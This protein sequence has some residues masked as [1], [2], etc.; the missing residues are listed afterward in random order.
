M[1]KFWP[2][3][4][5]E[6]YCRRSMNSYSIGKTSL[7]VREVLTFNTICLN[8][9]SILD[10]VSSVARDAALS[11]PWVY[12]YNLFPV[13]LDLNQDDFFLNLHPN[14]LYG[15]IDGT[16]RSGEVIR[17]ATNRISIEE[18]YLQIRYGLIPTTVIEDPDTFEKKGGPDWYHHFLSH[19][20]LMEMDL[21]ERWNMR[22]LFD[23]G[24]LPDEKSV[25]GWLR[26]GFDD[27]PE[28]IVG[29]KNPLI[30]EELDHLSQVYELDWLRFR[31]ISSYVIGE[32]LEGAFLELHRESQRMVRVTGQ[33]D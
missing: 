25:R 2:R 16:G 9:K 23:G 4:D 24:K 28:V 3:H 19:A 32:L 22:I 7:K 31:D 33:L 15:L 8:R 26:D 21:G 11:R 14:L 6:V 10:Y 29:G 12:E 17:A 30:T 1:K 20:K 5:N 27:G 18:P 13:G